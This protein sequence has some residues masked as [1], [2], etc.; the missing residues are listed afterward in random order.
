MSDNTMND[1]P[2]FMLGFLACCILV[3]A[4]MYWLHRRKD[5]TGNEYYNIPVEEMPDFDGG[6]FDDDE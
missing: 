5:N 1:S 2:E 4:V 3:V 6:L